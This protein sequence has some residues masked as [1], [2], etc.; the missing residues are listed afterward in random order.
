MPPII[1]P[2]WFYGFD[3]VMYFI[4]SMI[5]FLLS[6]YF[7]KIYSLS[8]EKKHMYLYTG[9]LLLSFGLLCLSITSIYS[10]TTFWQCHLPSVCTLGML[11]K[12]FGLEDFSYMLYFGLSIVTYTLF[13]MAYLPKN[14]KAPNL[15]LYVFMVYFFIIFI[16]LPLENGEVDWSSYQGFFN[17]T[18]FLMVAF[19]SF[20]NLINL[21]ENKSMDPFLVTS[22]FIFLSL[23]HLLHMFSFISGLVYVFAHISMLISFTL[24]LSVVVKVKRK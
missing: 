10:Y 6:F 15:P 24:L 16:T 19:V 12:A 5:G 9:F 23:F 7:H 4:S 3:S 8:S 14:F 21:S 2:V 18:A 20:M 17:M 11:D 1:I 22:A 13:I